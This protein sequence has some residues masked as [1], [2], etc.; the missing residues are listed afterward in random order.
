M[1]KGCGGF[2]FGTESFLE[3]QYE[4]VV[5]ETFSRTVDHGFREMAV[6]V[7]GTANLRQLPTTPHLYCHEQFLDDDGNYPISPSGRYA[8]YH[9]QVNLELFDSRSKS[10]VVIGQGSSTLSLF[11]WSLDEATLTVHDPHHRKTLTL[12]TQA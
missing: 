5:M 11:R 9:Y 6:S 2:A 1:K 10:M 3:R 7:A 8:A 12:T 4:G